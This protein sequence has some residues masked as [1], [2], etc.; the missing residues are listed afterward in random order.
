MVVCP[1]CGNQVDSSQDFCR[2]CGESVG[3]VEE[4]QKAR[5]H[6]RD[7]E[8][9]ITCNKISYPSMGG[10]WIRAY[11]ED[12]SVRVYPMDR[13]A[14]VEASPGLGN[15]FAEAEPGNV[16]VKEVDSFDSLSQM[17]GGLKDALS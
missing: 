3:D 7:A 2:N 9:S 11:M 14:Y 12:N 1:D 5:I 6:L 15:A 10:N 16:Q 4:V 8:K 13:I 17:L